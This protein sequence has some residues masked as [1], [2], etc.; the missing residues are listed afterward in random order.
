[1][2]NGGDGRFRQDVSAWLPTLWQG[3]PR[4]RLGEV[5]ARAAG[6]PFPSLVS[7]RPA[8]D[9]F[10]PGQPFGIVEP[11]A[12]RHPHQSAQHLRAGPSPRPADRRR[13]PR[14]DE[15]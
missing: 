10:M 14:L 6:S 1:M 15:E 8:P 5:G 3:M 2:G 11:R 7:G 4:Q 13:G 9:D 12:R